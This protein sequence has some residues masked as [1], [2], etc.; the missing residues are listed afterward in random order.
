[1]IVIPYGV[2]RNIIWVFAFA[3]RRRKLSDD[4]YRAICTAFSL[5][6]SCFCFDITDMSAMVDDAALRDDSALRY[7]ILR[8]WTF[9]S[10]RRIHDSVIFVEFNNYRLIIVIVIIVFIQWYSN[11]EKYGRVYFKGARGWYNTTRRY[12]F[13][14]NPTPPN[15]ELASSQNR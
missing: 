14:Y 6:L 12:V 4:L 3:I 15:T 1:M 10:E 9:S 2:A 5:T 13:S 8:S 7:W 11:S